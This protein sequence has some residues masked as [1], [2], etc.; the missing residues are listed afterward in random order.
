MGLKKLAGVDIKHLDLKDKKGKPIPTFSELEKANLGYT[1]DCGIDCCKSVIYLKD[2][3]T[4]VPSVLYIKGGAW[5]IKTK[6]D[7]EA[8]GY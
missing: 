6:A 4:G 2:V 7:F 8:N 3:A 1:C 5:I